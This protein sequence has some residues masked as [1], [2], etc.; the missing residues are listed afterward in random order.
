MLDEDLIRLEVFACKR[1]LPA[2]SGVGQVL[3]SDVGR[4]IFSLDQNRST[5]GM[6]GRKAERARASFAMSLCGTVQKPDLHKPGRARGWGNYMECSPLLWLRMERG[7]RWALDW[8]TSEF[9]QL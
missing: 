4:G 5:T 9:G 2:V 3:S 8:K 1:A 6:S 7:P